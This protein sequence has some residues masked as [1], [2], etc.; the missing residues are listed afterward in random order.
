MMVSFFIVWVALLAP[1]YEAQSSPPP[2]PPLQTITATSTTLDREDPRFIGYYSRLSTTERLSAGEGKEWRT[3]GRFAGDCE[4]TAKSCAYAT[5]CADNT[6]YFDDGNSGECIHGASC[7]QFTILQTSPDGWPSATN[8]NCRISWSAYTVYKQL[9]TT[10]TSS[11][12]PMPTSSTSLSASSDTLGSTSASVYQGPLRTGTSARGNN[13][14]NTTQIISAVIPAI[15][16]TALLVAGAWFFVHVRRKKKRQELLELAVD[17]VYDAP[18]SEETKFQPDGE[19]HRPWEL[20]GT[21]RPA[22]MVS[23]APQRVAEL[24]AS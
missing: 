2:P 20:D 9:A 13:G 18:R 21:G 6:L 1:L 17:G 7:V 5:Q 23:S 22:E 10:A 24:P 12:T 16:G 15:V 11:T 8:F 3:S 19:A 14:G 4:A